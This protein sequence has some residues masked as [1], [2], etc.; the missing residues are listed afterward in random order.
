MMVSPTSI[1]WLSRASQ[2]RCWPVLVW[3]WLLPGILAAQTSSQGR[4]T[5]YGGSGDTLYLSRAFLVPF[6]DTLRSL[7]GQPLPYTLDYVSGRLLPGWDSAQT[8]VVRYA[9]FADTLAREVALRKIRFTTDSLARPG[10]VDVIFD[11]A[12]D[13]QGW[14]WPEAE[15]IRKSGS[16]SRGITA[17]NNRSVSVNSGLR[18]QLEGD[19]GDGLQ[20]VGAITD[21]NIP[22][23][24]EGTTQQLS[25]FDRIFI[26]LQK[27]P[28]QVTVGDF[29][30][31]RKDSRFANFYRNVQGMQVGY[32]T[33]Q[34]QLRVSG[35]VAKGKFHSN[36]FAGK[37]GVAG[38]YR[39]SGKNG[40]RFFIVLAG[41]E[42]V[43]LNGQ[44]MQRGENADYVINYNTAEVTFTARHVIANIS[45]IVVDF[46][47]ND[48]YYN[49]SLVVAQGSQR[50][51]N[52]RLDL[53]FSYAR[54]ADNPN[55]PFEDAGALAQV[56]D[57]LRRV[58][59]AQALATSAGVFEVGYEEGQTRYARADTV[60]DGQVY[61]YYRRSTDPAVAVYQLYFSDVGQGRGSYRPAPGFNENV[62]AWVGPGQGSHEPVRNWVLPRMLQVADL[63]AD[64]K[65]GRQGLLY[66]ETSLS[67]EDKNRFSGL[68]DDDNL[69]LAQRTGL[70]WDRIRLAD[71]LVLRVDAHHQYIDARYENLDR[72]Y[73]AEYGRVWNFEESAERRRDEQIVSSQL[74]LRF[75]EQLS[76]AA[77]GGL[78]NTGPGRRAYRQVYTFRSQLP[79]MLQGQFAFTRIVN[80]DD[81]LARDAR[82]NR[83]EGDL[84]APLGAL[85]AGTVIWIEDK[86]ERRADTLAPGSYNFVD[87]KPYVRLRESES[88]Q[89]EAYFNYRHDREFLAGTLRDKSRAY[90]WYLQAAYRP[91]PVLNLQS[92]SSY[93]VLQVSDS[94]ISDLTGLLPTRTLGSNLQATFAPRNRLVYT[95]FI[96]EVGAEQLARTEVRYLR[97][98][99]GQGQ[100]VWLDSLFNQDGIQDVE[101]F[102]LANNPLVADFIRV[103]VPT[104]ELFPTTRL[105][106]AGNLR[107]DL[108]EVIP[109]SSGFWG[110][111][112][113]QTRSATVFRI[114]QSKAR[115]EQLAA[116][117]IDPFD[118]FGDTT[119]LSA[120]INF[121]QDLTFFQNSP[122]G[123]VRLFYQDA[124]SQLFLSTG[125]ELR[126]QQFYGL[127]LRYNFGPDRSAEWETRQGN[128]F[129]SAEA[130]ASRNYDIDFVETRPQFNIQFSRK[131]RVSTA[132]GYTFRRN[133]RPDSLIDSRVHIHKL[134]FDTRW[135]FRDRNSLLAK[136]ELVQVQQNGEPGFSAA[137]EMLEGLRPGANMVWQG[138]VSFFVLNNVELSITYDGRI[139]AVA[140]PVHTG[141]VQVRAFF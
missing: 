86:V 100:Y 46:E 83:Y 45:R 120:S 139:S 39:L 8:V 6:A 107:W 127:G 64:L 32:E 76:L 42:R 35:A 41:S 135:N 132:Y 3:L 26:R 7:G 30:L 125:K 80:E 29:E 79:K 126:G 61:T 94:L 62:F 31:Q 47:Y 96:Y 105:S 90:T 121:R 73:Q 19:L 88:L 34:S 12:D 5:L 138:F 65:I 50:L 93:R 102:Q 110:Q 37:D 116:Y 14:F 129:V 70:R 24:P 10:Q 52:D 140:P 13:T 98:N 97:V 53:R 87:L 77:E 18:L 15:G 33:A 109:A 72:L 82:W 123:D 75:R 59:D 51:W 134:V 17:G 56:L 49:R 54:D 1:G 67:S 20:I 95:N 89:L 66:T 16:L 4:D 78:R 113:R 130:F 119:L 137:Y 101:E 128:R 69:G 58:G 71:S 2:R 111:W 136:L 104:Q 60:L 40:E 92:I 99:P 84:Y 57:T 43:Y 114:I 115:S 27:N 103:I 11:E 55:A 23:Q 141:R 63:Q 22:V 133:T 124:R 108:R 118:P 36:A 117:V 74:E 91:G 122:K 48:R 106:L 44:Q 28:Y 38:P 131:L 68:G 81:S 21:E 112:L 85:R 9:S 25:D